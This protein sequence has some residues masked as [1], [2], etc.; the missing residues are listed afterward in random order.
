MKSPIFIKK[1]IEVVN[2]S[3]SFSPS[4][5]S[6]PFLQEDMRSLN[7][8]MLDKRVITKTPV[9]ASSELQVTHQRKRKE[10][11]RYPCSCLASRTTS[12]SL[13][14][15]AKRWTHA[16]F[17]LVKAHFQSTRKSWTVPDYTFSSG[18]FFI[19]PISIVLS[20]ASVPGV[21]TDDFL[22]KVLSF[23][24]ALTN[25]D[26][27]QLRIKFVQFPCALLIYFT[28]CFL[29]YH[30]PLACWVCGMFLRRVQNSSASSR[31]TTRIRCL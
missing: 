14:P 6:Y 2:A 13:H 9:Q 15:Q 21:K 1:E 27:A 24:G 11:L 8:A 28:H 5:F 31:S 16:C 17:L 10:L 18:L 4:S 22:N 25:I 20:F 7:E 23:S 12:Q 19:N 3:P 29:Y 30:S 26:R